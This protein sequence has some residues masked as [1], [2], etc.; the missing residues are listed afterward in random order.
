MVRLFSLLDAFFFA[1]IPAL[2][3]R[4]QAIE[5]FVMPSA[6]MGALG[7]IH[8]ALADDFYGLFTNPASFAG[9][10]EEMSAGEITA[11]IYGP[12]FKMLDLVSTPPESIDA[13]RLIG[14]GE[15]IDSGRLAAG[16]DIGGPVALGWVGRGVGLGLFNRTKIDA[17][18]SGTRLRS[19]AAAEVFLLGG[20]SFRFLSRD[21]HTLDGGFL[22][23]GFFRQHL[24]LGIS[25]P[26][27]MDFMAETKDFPDPFK[28]PLDTH[29]GLGFDLGLRYNFAEAFSAALVCYDVYAPVL[30][31]AYA[32]A[33]GPEDQEDQVR[34]GSYGTIKPRL[35]LGLMYRV[36][37]SVLERYISNFILLADYRDFFDLL[38]LVPR[39]PILNVGLGAELVMFEVL[40]LRVGI[41][42]ALPAAGFGL[43]LA[44]LRFN[45]AIHG[46][47]LGLDPGLQP[48]YAVD[49]GIEFR[50]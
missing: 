41:T 43:D 4:A 40:S 17:S 24:Q 21:S 18:V 31:S 49:L 32:K 14:P 38:S 42:D 27:I 36:R 37:S 16:L 45:C 13:A 28:Q 12:V 11:A 29:L 47:E 39:N 25:L 20:Y 6:R 9:L 33:G 2:C 5:P 7:G 44:V 46:R 15:L 50:Y 23:K 1:L 3:L 35:N 26:D 30:V 8:A 48:V 19:A 22:G 10:E 34:T